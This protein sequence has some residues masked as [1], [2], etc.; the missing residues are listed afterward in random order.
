MSAFPSPTP[1]GGSSGLPWSACIA[2]AVAILSLQALAL[3]GLGQPPVCQCGYVK[4]WHGVVS[5]PENSQHLTDWYTHTHVIHG[6]V[7]YLLLWLVAPRMPIGLRLVLAIGIEATWEVM[8]NTPFIINR[9]RQSA[10]AQ[11]YFGDSIINSIVDTLATALGFL[12]ARL[13]PV[14]I[15]IAL[16]IT[17]ELFAAYMIRDN[18][19]LN[20]VQLVYPTETVSRWQT[21]E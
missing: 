16:A 1:D 19:A 21:G 10:L 17:L 18:L 2:T 12:L 6:L 13:L 8:E 7:W 15:I 11:G 14:W 3:L 9:Y 20:I 4:F 5:S